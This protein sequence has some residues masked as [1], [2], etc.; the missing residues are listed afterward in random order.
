VGEGGELP[1][2]VPAAVVGDDKVLAAAQHIVKS[3]ASSKNAADDM[4]R[5]LS[6]FDNR[7]SLMSDLFPP[8]PSAAAVDSI[9]ETD[10]GTSQGEGDDPVAR[11]EAEW[12]AAAE[13][14][15]RWESPAAGDALVFDS[16]EDAEEYLAAAACLAGAPG[17]RADAALQAAM[18]R[19]EDE[20]RHLLVHGALPLAAEDRRRDLSLRHAWSQGA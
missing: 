10:E 11:A 14:I 20:F 13:V 17:P 6:G 15:E 7:L 1:V 16:R 3:L 12:D 4:I 2:P 19:L 18:A 9:L 8:P 5:I